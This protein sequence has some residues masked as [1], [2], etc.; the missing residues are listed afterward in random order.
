MEPATD[1][2]C[3]LP[4]GLVLEDGRRLSQAELRPLSGREEEW[5]ARHPWS[6]STVAV[7]HLLSTCLLRLDDQ[8]AQRDHARRLLVGDREYLMLHLRRITLGETIRAVLTCPACTAKMD[9]DFQAAD[10]P[11]ERRPQTAASYTL[12][13]TS[14]R[15]VRFRLPTGADQEAVLGLATEQAV[16]ALFARS[17]LDDSGTALLPGEQSAVIEAMDRLAPQ[18]ELELELV[19]PECSHEFVAP[20]DTTR[21]FLDEMRTNGHQLVREV[22]HLAFHYHWSETGILR[23][24]RSRRH[25]YLSLLTETLRQQ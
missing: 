6:P 24:T 15:T 2:V 25:M 13:L 22:H 20:F 1:G 23:L 17:L 21:F 12:D 19:C 7:T 10:V 11:V 18:I 3:P 9:V 14:G 8:P 4:G 16:E 5:L